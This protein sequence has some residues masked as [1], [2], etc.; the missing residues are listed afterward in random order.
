MCQFG[1]SVLFGADP[2]EYVIVLGD[3]IS[4]DMLPRGTSCHFTPGCA[5]TPIRGVTGNL[6]WV[7]NREQWLKELHFSSMPALEC[8]AIPPTCMWQAPDDNKPTRTKLHRAIPTLLSRA[9]HLSGLAHTLDLSSRGSSE[10]GIYESLRTAAAIAHGPPRA[11]S[12]EILPGQLRD[13]AVASLAAAPRDRPARWAACKRSLHVL[14]YDMRIVKTRRALSNFVEQLVDAFKRK[15]VKRAR[16]AEG[17]SNQ[18]RKIAKWLAKEANK[19]A[20][21]EEKREKAEWK[22]NIVTRYWVEGVGRPLSPPTEAVPAKLSKKARAAKAAAERKEKID[23]RP[24]KDA[25][26]V[27]IAA[28]KPHQ[29]APDEP[30]A[31]LLPC[32]ICL[33]TDHDPSECPAQSR[34]QYRAG[35]GLFRIESRTVVCLHCKKAGH[36]VRECPEWKGPS[37]NPAAIPAVASAAVSAGAVAYC[38]PKKQ[39]SQQQQQQ[40]QASQQQQAPD[41]KK[42]TTSKGEQQMKGK[43]AA[44][45]STK[46]QNFI[47]DSKKKCPHC[48]TRHLPIFDCPPQAQKHRVQ[49]NKQNTQSPA[50]ATEYPYCNACKLFGHYA[51]KCQLRKM[52]A[53]KRIANMKAKNK[54]KMTAPPPPKKFKKDDEE[55]KEK[56]DGMEMPQPPM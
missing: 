31:S 23:A 55:K 37:P 9:K 47:G 17:V 11:T 10:W 39:A 2:L 24:G 30:E 3:E 13:A 35:S 27:A 34:D 53:K 49:E 50:V 36:G 4:V 8:A 6:A 46:R 20:R 5:Y 45:A 44:P 42:K 40:Q 21:A 22:M 25:D 14:E 15:M 16:V 33:E 54:K 7:T 52:K 28:P 32:Y 18:D 12:P 48:G 1:P 51:A 56:D 19:A 29:A 41:R 26:Q 43:G 38:P